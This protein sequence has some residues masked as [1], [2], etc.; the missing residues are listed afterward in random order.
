MSSSWL[1]AQRWGWTT[2]PDHF[3]ASTFYFPAFLTQPLRGN[4][5]NN[6]TVHASRWRLK[7]SPKAENIQKAENMGNMLSWQHCWGRQ[8]T[9][10]LHP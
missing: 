2:V 7:Y 5:N 10:Y 6:L 4:S 3:W 1:A 9:R 8:E